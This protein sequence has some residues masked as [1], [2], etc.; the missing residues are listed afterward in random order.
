MR[1]YMA[2]CGRWTLA[3]IG[4]AVGLQVVGNATILAS[5][6]AARA[7]TLPS[8]ALDAHG[9]DNFRIVDDRVWRGAAPTN[10]GYHWLS[11]HGVTTIIDLRAEAAAPPSSLPR[12]LGFEV[13]RLPV[14][15]GQLPSQEQIDEA[16]EAIHS[17]KGRTFIHCSAGVGRTGAIIAS[18]LVDTGQATGLSALVRN[19]AVGPPSLEQIAFVA[20]ADRDGAVR[21]G[22]AVVIASRFLDAPRK[23][24]GQLT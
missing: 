8:A 3:L 7:L 11:A 24:W 21:P 5:T 20:T 16:L 2:R 17:S 23:L 9:I 4:V 19:L 13:I 22:A 15:D 10:A 1:R 6:F 18:Y 14:R 12:E